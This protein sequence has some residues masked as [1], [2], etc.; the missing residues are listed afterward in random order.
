L[1][2]G[3]T[4]QLRLIIKHQIIG[5]LPFKKDR[6]NLEKRSPETY[7]S[8]PTRNWTLSS[9]LGISLLFFTQKTLKMGIVLRLSPFLVDYNQQKEQRPQN[10]EPAT[11]TCFMSSAGY[12][13]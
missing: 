4:E 10:S 2:S 11:G 8:L 7:L 3:T 5:N 9:S 12:I 6:N 13:F 1:S